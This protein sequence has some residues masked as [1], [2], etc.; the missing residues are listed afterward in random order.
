MG[1]ASMHM[2]KKQDFNRRTEG[3]EREKTSPI[4]SEKGIFS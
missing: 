4:Y 1:K 2:L 3:L